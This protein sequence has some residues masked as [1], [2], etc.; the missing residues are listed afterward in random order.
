MKMIAITRILILLLLAGLLGACERGPDAQAL[1]TQVQ[2]TLDQQFKEGLFEVVSLKRAGSAPFTDKA[3][4][5]DKHSISG[6]LQPHRMGLPEFRHA[7]VFVG[8]HGKRH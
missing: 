6:R 7:G 1:R 3:S 5:D 8:R 4:A 2:S